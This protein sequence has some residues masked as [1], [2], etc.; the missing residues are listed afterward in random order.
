MKNDSRKET[1]ALWQTRVFLFLVE[2]RKHDSRSHT[3]Q[4]T[5]MVQRC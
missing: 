3:I 2:R 4:Q 5:K 1:N